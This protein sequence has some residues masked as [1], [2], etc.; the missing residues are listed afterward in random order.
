[1][2]QV[3]KVKTRHGT[4]I[5]EGICKTSVLLVPSILLPIYIG[6]RWN[7]VSMKRKDPFFPT[8]GSFARIDRDD[9]IYLLAILVAPHYKITRGP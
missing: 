5:A 4:S 3:A 6:S 7:A 1:M 8:K 9:F 2:T